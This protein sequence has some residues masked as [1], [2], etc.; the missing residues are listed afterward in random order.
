MC[1]ACLSY[2]FYA[3]WTRIALSNSDD[4]VSFEAWEKAVFSCHFDMDVT[5]VL[6]L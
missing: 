1:V 3:G 6:A 4:S 2:A 5:E